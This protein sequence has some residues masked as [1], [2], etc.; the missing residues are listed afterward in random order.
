MN[1]KEAIIFYYRFKLM[2]INNAWVY[3]VRFKW[4]VQSNGKYGRD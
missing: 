1:L 4:P 3:H 2:Y